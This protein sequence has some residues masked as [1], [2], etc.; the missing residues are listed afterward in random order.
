MGVSTFEFVASLCVRDSVNAQGCGGSLES[1]RFVEG[2]RHPQLEL[3]YGWVVSL[4]VR[5]KLG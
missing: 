3:S 4:L 2:V 1:S 5:L